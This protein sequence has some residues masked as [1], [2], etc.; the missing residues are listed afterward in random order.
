MDN[1][2]YLLKC[3]D[4]G[5]AF[6]TENEKIFYANMGFVLPKRCKNCRYAKKKAREQSEQIKA[7]QKQRQQLEK[8]I[9]E[10]P[11]CFIE[12]QEIII[13]NP[14]LTL[15]VI[16]NG[17]DIIHGVS[18]SYYNFRD[19]LGRRSELRDML[20]TYIMK[21]DLWAD[22][23]DSLAYL[24]A[25]ILIDNASE[26]MDIFDV[27]E[28]DNDNFS[29]ADFFVA[30]ETAAMPAL[31][32]PCE[33]PKRFR[34][35]IETLQPSS[36]NK[37]LSDLINRKCRYINFNYTE[38]LESLYGVP[39]DKITYIHGCR[40]NKKEE[41]ILGHAP[42][43]DPVDYETAGSQ[44]KCSGKRMTQ[45]LYD[46]QETTGN[47][48]GEY[49]DATTKK[50]DK[51]IRNN[52][53]FFNNIADLGAIITIGHSLSPVD[54]PYFKAMIKNNKDFTNIAWYIGWHSADDLRR[55]QNFTDKMEISLK[56]IKL[57][58]I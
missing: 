24:N 56:W 20:E 42:E 1:Q 41:L 4:C 31:T 52:D 28:Q 10:S 48:I 43:V 33:L 11:F 22:F 51:I 44:R 46:L 37:P 47:Y 12:R 34:R 27:L 45:T 49:F 55:I 17:F 58:R 15:F 18:S 14:D 26:C 39:K 25:E 16:G 13:N 29:A 53:T 23:E 57:F 54:Y 3:A 5:K 9:T 50:T 19:W 32:I 36:D 38:F 40:Q 35:W 8:A 6:F 30:A 2:T 7:H 21:A